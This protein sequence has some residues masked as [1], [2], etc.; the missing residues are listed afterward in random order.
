MPRKPTS[1]PAEIDVQYW[2]LEL[3]SAVQR[4]EEAI[5]ALCR[6]GDELSDVRRKLRAARERLARQRTPTVIRPEAV[7]IHPAWVKDEAS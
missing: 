1:S 5:E 3:V 4:H 6:A 2:E 7:R